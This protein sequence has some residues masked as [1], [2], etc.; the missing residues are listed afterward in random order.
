MGRRDQRS[1]SK[2]QEP[3]GP[4]AHS[5]SQG[6]PG[7][8]SRSARRYANVPARSRHTD[9]GVMQGPPGVD[10]AGLEA[11]LSNEF[12]WL[13][14]LDKGQ[15]IISL[16]ALRLA[17]ARYAIDAANRADALPD[18]SETYVSSEK[19]ARRRARE[20]WEEKRTQAAL[21][22]GALPEYIA[23]G[24][25]TP[26]LSD[27]FG[28]GTT[29]IEELGLEAMIQAIQS[30]SGSVR[31]RVNR[32]DMQ[33]TLYLGGSWLRVRDDRIHFEA[34]FETT[35]TELLTIQQAYY[36]AIL[37]H[38][39]AQYEEY[40]SEHPWLVQD[41]LEERIAKQRRA[42]VARL[43]AEEDSGSEGAEL[44]GM[45]RERRE[46]AE[47]MRTT[48]AATMV[49]LA[50]VAA[51]FAIEGASD[52]FLAL[53]PFGKAANLVKGLTR[54]GKS[55]RRLSQTRRAELAQAMGESEAQFVHLA[56]R[57][58]PA[59]LR[60]LGSIVEKVKTPEVIN[61]LL[62]QCVGGHADLRWI[63]KHLD[64]GTFDSAFIGHFLRYNA[65]PTWNQLRGLIDNSLD[66]KSRGS[67]VSK[68]LG[69]L[70]EEA[71]ARHVQS[72]AFS[73]RYF[74][75]SEPMA[76]TRGEKKLDL[77]VTDN[78]GRMLVGETKNWSVET[79]S[80][81]S[82]QQELFKQLAKHNGTIDEMARTAGNQ[83]VA[84]RVLLVTERGFTALASDKRN[85]VTRTVKRLGWTVEVIPGENLESMAQFIDRMRKGGS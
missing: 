9:D 31:L 43:L 57:L 65:N 35:S 74:K 5:R 16:S 19:D 15:E 38:S 52:V 8:S 14:K 17:W 34:F 62:A 76:V 42:E 23:V 7:G 83:A 71:G 20:P 66:S 68:M 82:Q 40:A 46:L 78:E 27:G 72:E 58:E 1:E 33:I 60:A 13:L 69:F 50:V 30:R 59:D 32:D 53:F 73:R 51:F 45:V 6:K 81:P 84:G 79:W 37:Q 3:F 28:V 48:V 64:D 29:P 25:V 61:L 54:R 36:S 22:L 67:V 41:M 44:R 55:A 47:N 10:L 12:S 70:G 63:A 39:Q 49:P 18:P 77:V 26:L 4:D 85:E 11:E 21:V 24:D 80:N 56:R 75:R 2:D